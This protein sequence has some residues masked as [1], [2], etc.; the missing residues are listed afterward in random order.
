MAASWWIVNMS[1]IDV[2]LGWLSTAAGPR[3]R[4]QAWVRQ[5]AKL[6]IMASIYMVAREQAK[7]YGLHGSVGAWVPYMQTL[8]SQLWGTAGAASQ[9]PGST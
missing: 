5:L 6:A 3:R 4:R 2:P 1:L 7:S 8:I 9:P